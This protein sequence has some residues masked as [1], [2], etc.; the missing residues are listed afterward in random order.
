MK[1]PSNS[2]NDVGEKQ[3]YG[4]ERFGAAMFMAVARRRK[5]KPVKRAAKPETI[6]APAELTKAADT[7]LMN[8]VLADQHDGTSTM[9]GGPP[10]VQKSIPRIW[11]PEE[12]QERLQAKQVRLKIR[13]AQ[14]QRIC[15]EALDLPRR[16]GSSPELSRLRR[17]R[18]KL[19]FGA[20]LKP[21]AG[22]ADITKRAIAS[23]PLDELLHETMRCVPVIDKDAD[24][25][26]AV[27]RLLPVF[28]FLKIRLSK[29]ELQA[30]R[31]E[32]EAVQ[33]EL[34]F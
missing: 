10:P 18:E 21:S 12:K 6:P 14:C 32:A 34:I 24:F 3:Q 2:I 20:K 1:Q 9:V 15:S 19:A 26:M 16:K 13:I 33:L 4:A 28:R 17:E 11:S 8:V 25:K 7:A 23:S 5:P 31:T 27:K 30:L 22:A 29:V